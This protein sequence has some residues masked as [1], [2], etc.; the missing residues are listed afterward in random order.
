MPGPTTSESVCRGIFPTPH[1][2][3][4]QTRTLYEV[5]NR[6]C[7]EIRLIRLHI[8]DHNSLIQCDL[9]PPVSLSNVKGEYSAIS[10]CAGDPNNTRPIL[11][12]GARFNVFANLA[13]ALDIT[14]DFWTK[15][16]PDQPTSCLI[17]ADQICIDQ[18]NLAERSHQV[19][20][21]PSIYSSAART[22]VCLSTTTEHNNTRDIEWLLQL[23]ATVPPGDDYYAYYFRL[24][25][26]LRT[27]LLSRRPHHHHHTTITTT[28]D[29][30]E[31]KHA[32]AF[33]SGWLAFYDTVF[34]SPWWLRTWVYQEFISSA[35]RGIHF[36]Y[37]RAS[38]AWSHVSEV[39]PTLRKYRDLGHL[40]GSSGAE[41]GARQAQVA[42]VVDAVHFFVVS[43]MRFD[44]AGPC[45]LLE[46]LARSR[47]LRS[48]DARDRVYA[49]LG[50][51]REDYGIVPDYSPENG[52]ERLLV[53]V[54]RR[55]V[56]RDRTLDILSYACEARGDLSR[57]LPSRVP[58]WT[59]GGCGELRGRSVKEP[60]EKD[61]AWLPR[62]HESGKLEVCGCKIGT[63]GKGPVLFVEVQDIAHWDGWGQEGDELWGL[64]GARSAFI[65]REVSGG[66][67]LVKEANLWGPGPVDLEERMRQNGMQCQSIF[68]V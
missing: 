55:V 60:G 18:T 48:T 40:G 27:Q 32:K 10:Y 50:L 16:F 49:F 52:I 7:R 67:R 66:F 31:G 51:V 33:V 13:H 4:F 22:L 9:L 65:L 54:A 45:D 37:G 47:H 42:D 11:L 5:L 14:R 3:E 58:D 61:T 23:H 17:W 35:H 12:N 21:M 56:M 24:E 2:D 29:N 6:S 57:R 59:C 38:V 39:L 36:L 46:L 26:H 43:K 62:V 53:D 1:N 19:G 28:N 34:R 68:I 25:H 63:F 8:T 15:N 44:R 20:F 64:I 41:L 30:P